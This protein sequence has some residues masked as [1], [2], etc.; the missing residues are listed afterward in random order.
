MPNSIE[1]PASDTLDLIKTH[2]R[3][4]CRLRRNNNLRLQRVVRPLISVSGTSITVT[5]VSNHLIAGN[6]PR[7]GKT[8]PKFFKAGSLTGSTITGL[9]IENN[10]PV[11]R[12]SIFPNNN[13]LLDFITIDNSAGDSQGGHNTDAFDLGT[14]T[15]ITTRNANVKN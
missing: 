3:D 2:I 12:S 14:S 6:G 10:T 8:Y 13:I 4:A 15:A 7:C 9:N 1:F 11:Q 5:G